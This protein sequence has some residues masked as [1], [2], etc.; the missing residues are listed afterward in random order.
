MVVV[1]IILARNYL[2]GE[3]GSNLIRHVKSG[4]IFLRGLFDCHP[5]DVQRDPNAAE[6]A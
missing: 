4:S 3:D 2:D 1:G 6:L 5:D